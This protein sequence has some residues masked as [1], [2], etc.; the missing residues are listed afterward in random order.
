MSDRQIVI[1]GNVLL[2]MGPIGTFFGRFAKYLIKNNVKTYKIC[3]PL[4]E[5]F[6]PK[7]CRV[8]FDKDMNEFETFLDKFI[9]EKNIKHIFMYGN[10]ILPHRIAIELGSKLRVDVNVF[11]LGY[12]RPRYITLEKNVNALSTLTKNKNYYSSLPQIFELPKNIE[13]KK[14][15][16]EIYAVLAFMQHALNGYKISDQPHKLQPKPSYLLKQVLGY[17]RY[18][19][20]KFTEYCIRKKLLD[21]DNI[22]MV[23]LQVSIDSQVTRASKFNSIEEFIHTIVKSFSKNS[24]SSSM[25]VFKHHPRDRGYNNY[26]KFINKV[27]TYYEIS[28]RVIYFHEADISE[29]YKKCNGVILINS[30][31]GIETL[32]NNIPTLV[33]GDAFYDINEITSQYSLDDFWKSSSC[34]NQDLFKK[35]Y[36]SMVKT[37]QLEGT[38]HEDFEFGKYFKFQASK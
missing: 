10:F 5:F 18:Y 16:Y 13:S 26:K 21:S 36:Q 3:F 2:L 17:V 14:Q 24:Y 22:F 32:K 6:V 11:E 12:V 35:F 30:T 23:P 31:M 9:R 4:K 29:L 28:E 37:T 8:H 34:V 19:T 27:A 7:S 25:L 15:R 1:S 20:Y 33:L 38:F